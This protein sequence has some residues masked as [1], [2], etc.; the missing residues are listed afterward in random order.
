M[1]RH[2]SNHELSQRPTPEEDEQRDVEPIETRGKDWALRN[3]SPRAVP[4]RRT[5]RIIVRQDQ[6]TILPDGALP[7]PNATSGAPGRTVAM[8]GDTVQSIDKFVG[9]V[10]AEIDGWGLA[11]DNLYWRPILELTV[12]PDG[13]QRADDLRR[14]LSNSGLELGPSEVANETTQGKPNGT[15]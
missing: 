1:P 8:K 3:K 7:N 9:Q 14:L 12:G 2:A 13:Q 11:G 6:L 4:V 5:I 15:R 10:R